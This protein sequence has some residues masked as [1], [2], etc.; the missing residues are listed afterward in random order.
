M[1]NIVLLILFLQLIWINFLHHEGSET[2]EQAARR[3]FGCTT[4]GSVQG[5]ARRGFE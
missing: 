4:P 2:L 5:Q 1:F 3:R